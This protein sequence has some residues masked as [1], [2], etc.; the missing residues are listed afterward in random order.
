MDFSGIPPIEIE[1][2][3]EEEG[4]GEGG[5]GG[6]LDRSDP[7]DDLSDDETMASSTTAPPSTHLKRSNP[8]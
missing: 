6:G 1:N 8:C 3:K 7:G 2:K 4:E 5:G